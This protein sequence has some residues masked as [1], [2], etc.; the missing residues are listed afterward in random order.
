MN[1]RDIMTANPIVVPL[2]ATIADALAI[3]HDVDIRHVPV[4][5]EDGQLAGLLSDRDVRSYNLPGLV[6]LQNPEK[7]ARRLEAAVSTIMQADVASVGLE[8]EVAEIVQLMIDHKFGAI[9][10]VDEMDGTL[11]GIV[12][13]L[14][15]LRALAEEVDFL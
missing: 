7:A 5:D 3:L 1:A 4:I 11:V 6:A 14:D 13:Y 2:T 9:P 8:T 10:V 12:S 15:L